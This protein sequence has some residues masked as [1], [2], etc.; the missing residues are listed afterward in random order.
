MLFFLQK[1]FNTIDGNANARRAE[2][3]TDLDKLMKDAGYGDV[4]SRFASEGKMGKDLSSIN[5]SFETDR[6]TGEV[7]EYLEYRFKS[8]FKD[9]EY[10][11]A[12]LNEAVLKAKK[13]FNYN[14]NK[15]N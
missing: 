4:K 7:K 1:T 13:E 14:P 3:Y 10:D 5:K 6:E 8:N 2:L 12:V 9:Y 15:K 11:L